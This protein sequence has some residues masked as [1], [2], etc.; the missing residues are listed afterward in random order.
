MIKNMADRG[1]YI[2]W[3]ELKEEARGEIVGRPHFAKIMLRKGYVESYQEAFDKYLK[4]GKP[5][6]LNKKR[7]DPDKAIELI[8]NAGGIP[9]IAHPYQT[10]L[11]N[12]QLEQLIKKLIDYGLKGIEVFYS[13]H[14]KSQIE[15]YLNYARKYNLLITGGSDFH[16]SNKPEI[17]LGMDVNEKYIQ[18]FL[19]DGD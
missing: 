15:Q 6:Y 14:S 18:A 10:N 3:E 2:S 7:L 9:V 11:E 1:F 19:K 4:K 8:I 13:L 17:Q 16:G 5:L 12:N